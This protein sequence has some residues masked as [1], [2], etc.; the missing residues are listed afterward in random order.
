LVLPS[1]QRCRPVAVI[2]VID[3]DPDPPWCV[4]YLDPGSP[5][6]DRHAMDAIPI[7]FRNLKNDVGY[8]PSRIHNTSIT[9]L[10]I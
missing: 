2:A 10:E 7:R 8:D 9:S 5:D 1:P 6:L 3:T 4:G